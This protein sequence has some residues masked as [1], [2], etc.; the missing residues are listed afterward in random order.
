[1]PLLTMDAVQMEDVLSLPILINLAPQDLEKQGIL[2]I[3][4]FYRICCLC[5]ILYKGSCR[6]WTVIE[7]IFLFLFFLA[8]R[9]FFEVINGATTGRLDFYGN[10]VGDFARLYGSLRG[11]SN[12]NDKWD[13]DLELVKVAKSNIPS[14]NELAQSC[15]L[16]NIF[17]LQASWDFYALRTDVPSRLV[18]KGINDG[19]TINIAFDRSNMYRAQIGYGGSKKNVRFGLT[20]WISYASFSY[21]E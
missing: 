4:S 14:K 9:W 10:N 8:F 5:Y 19:C 13:L 12:V 15:S 17:D 11:E 21:D 7:Y 18:G 20:S 2:L 16:A 6:K 3:L 1:M